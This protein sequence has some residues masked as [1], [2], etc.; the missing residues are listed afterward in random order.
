MTVRVEAAVGKRGDLLG[1]LAGL[2]VDLDGRDG[3]QH[4]EPTAVDG[5]GELNHASR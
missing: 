1:S 2:L 4:V 5:N 3:K